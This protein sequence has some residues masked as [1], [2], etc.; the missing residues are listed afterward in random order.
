MHLYVHFSSFETQLW[1]VW[2]ENWFPALS[3]PECVPD[4]CVHASSS[5]W[6]YNHDWWEQR[7]RGCVHP[8]ISIHLLL[9]Q[10]RLWDTLLTSQWILGDF[11]CRDTEFKPCMYAIRNP[12]LIISYAL[13]FPFPFSF[14]SLSS[15]CFPSFPLLL[16]YSAL[17]LGLSVLV[18][19]QSSQ[20]HSS[21]LI[22]SWVQFTWH[23]WTCLCMVLR[24]L[25]SM[26]IG[27]RESDLLKVINTLL[28]PF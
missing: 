26:D 15:Y 20:K 13:L 27:W 12:I 24:G 17:P 14:H 8:N 25:T 21:N 18:T 23:V 6:L 2:Y 10:Q 5:V 7:A 16:H 28:G 11:S 1:V 3:L 9:I 19:R 4:G 22:C